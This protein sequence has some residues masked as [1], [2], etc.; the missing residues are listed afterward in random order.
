LGATPLIL[1]IKGNIICRNEL[2]IGEQK[3]NKT[4]E[5]TQNQHTRVN[6]P[7]TKHRLVTEHPCSAAT[8]PVLNKKKNLWAL[9][10]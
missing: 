6:W 4:K 2:K 10:F 3:K 5:L 1:I 7:I 8:S 9:S